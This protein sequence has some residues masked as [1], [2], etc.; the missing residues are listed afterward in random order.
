MGHG[1]YIVVVVRQNPV[2]PYVT[3]SK[4]DRSDAKALLEAFR[5]DEIRPVPVKTELQHTLAA[6]HRLRSTWVRTRTSRLN[7]LRGLLRELGI[8]SPLGARHVVPAVRELVEDADSCLSD[9]V[10]LVFF[11]ACQEIQALEERIETA[12]NQLEAISKS[13]PTVKAL[14]SIPGVGLLT[15]TALVGF[16][17]D[18]QRFPSSRHF[19]SYLG[20][21]PREYSSGQ[22]RRLGRISKF[23]VWIRSKSP[24]KR[25]C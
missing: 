18:I 20:L 16:V 12:R 17:G 11:E 7:T 6:L 13:L 8:T 23:R 15:S 9:P 21:T 5:N 1:P 14:Q 10:R 24:N 2:H 3:R 19:A 25:H 22:K 4:T